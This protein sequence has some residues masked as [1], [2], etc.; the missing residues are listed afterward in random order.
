MDWYRE[1]AV[2]PASLTMVG[3]YVFH[4]RSSVSLRHNS[5]SSYGASIHILLLVRGQFGDDGI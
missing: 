3:M 1:L 4:F 5:L 2:L